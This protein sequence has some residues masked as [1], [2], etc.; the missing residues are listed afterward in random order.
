[1]EYY[2]MTPERNVR[3]IQKTGLVPGSLRS[4]SSEAERKAVGRA[5]FLA[6]SWEEARMQLDLFG[7]DEPGVRVRNWAI[8]RVSLPEGHTL[9]EDYEGYLYTTLPIPPS[10]LELVWTDTAWRKKMLEE[11]GH[12]YGEIKDE[13]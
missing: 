2:H 6:R 7:G 10:R 13:A 8:F 4:F 5:I 12:D 11:Y 9:L 1:M 3:S